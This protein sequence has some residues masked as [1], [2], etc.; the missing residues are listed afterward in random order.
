[1]KIFKKANGKVAIRTDKKE[2]L[3]I[4]Q[5]LGID[6]SSLGTGGMGEAPD[7]GS[8]AGA[9]LEDVNSS[10][11]LSGAGD[12][13]DDSVVNPEGD[14]LGSSGEEP[15]QKI[16][17]LV[18]ELQ[19]ALDELDGSSETSGLDDIGGDDEFD[20]NV[21]DTSDLGDGSADLNNINPADQAL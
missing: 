1:M 3:R 9:G 10:P 16:R 14:D 12:G 18:G 15:I 19:S 2:W 21:D 7:A 11:D 8:G 4:G 5:Q 17:R 13:L 6:T 20:T